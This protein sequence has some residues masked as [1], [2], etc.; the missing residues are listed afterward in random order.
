MQ[1][2]LCGCCL[3]PSDSCATASWPL[4]SP[5]VRMSAGHC[6]YLLLHVATASHHPSYSP[7]TSSPCC[8]HSLSPSSLLSPSPPPCCPQYGCRHLFLI[9]SAALLYP[10]PCLLPHCH[11]LLIIYH[12]QRYLN[13]LCGMLSFLPPFLS[14]CNSPSHLPVATAISSSSPTTSHICA[15]LFD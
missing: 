2:Y 7:S 1:R 4:Y 15:T 10:P 5:L 8:R 3:S 13:L 6:H 11:R 12:F 9:V 14:P